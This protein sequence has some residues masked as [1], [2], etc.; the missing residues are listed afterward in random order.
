MDLY[1]F[2]EE[3]A[4]EFERFDHPPV[5]TCEQAKLLTPAMPGADTKNL[6]LRDKKGRRHFLVVVGHEHDID[7]R[8]LSGLL[9]VTNLSFASAERLKR[10]LDIEPGAVSLLAV[11]NDSDG[12]VEVVVD[13]GLWQSEALRCHPLVNTSTLVI[14][15]RDLAKFLSITEHDPRVIAVPHKKKD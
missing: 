3:H 10:Y 14:Q 11:L 1:R 15:R 4:I 5:F 2:L 12:A 13:Q 6:L 7:I 8:A 9:E